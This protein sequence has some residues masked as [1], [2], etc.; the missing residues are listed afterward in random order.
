MRGPVSRLP[1]D[2]RGFR[3]TVTKS[4]RNRTPPPPARP[5]AHRSLLSARSYGGG[6]DGDANGAA[7]RAA[8]GP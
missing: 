1:A 6:E 2:V 4:R 7:E 5:N 3:W 8:G